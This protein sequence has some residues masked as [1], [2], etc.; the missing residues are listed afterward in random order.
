[1]SGHGGQESHGGGAFFET[2]FPEEIQ[3]ITRVMVYAG[4][5]WFFD[6]LFTGTHSIDAGGGHGGGGNH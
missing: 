3:E 6:W 1:M 5:D 4:L 2:P